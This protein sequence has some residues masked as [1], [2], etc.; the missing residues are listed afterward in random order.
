[1]ELPTLNAQRS[2]PNVQLSRKSDFLIDPTRFGNRRSLRIATH[3][4]NC[5]RTSAGTRIGRPV[6]ALIGHQ[7][8]RAF[9]KSWRSLS[10]RISVKRSNV[11]RLAL[12]TQVRKMILL[13]SEAGVL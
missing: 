1:M 13:P 8:V 11:S 2:M 9:D 6:C 7:S 4:E 12:P 10:R 5:A 3:V